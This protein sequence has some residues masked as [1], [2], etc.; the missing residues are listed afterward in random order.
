LQSSYETYGD[1]SGV[2]FNRSTSTLI[3]GHQRLKTLKHKK[4]KISVEP[5][6][7]AYGTVAIGNILVREKDGTITKIPYRE[8]SW[9]DAK[10][11][12]AANIAANAGGGQFDTDKLSS[13][14]EELDTS[15][16]FVVETLGLDPLTIRQ[17][18]SLDSDSS[19]SP[20][21]TKTHEPSSSAGFQ[22]YDEDSFEF[23]HECPKCHYKW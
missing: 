9:T 14:L 20:K 18:T 23:K 19:K 3:S 4:T 11:E 22:E 21:S 12:M 7:D 6:T 16:A 17:L 13:M 1:L 8:V 10:A 15:D 5:H 2:V